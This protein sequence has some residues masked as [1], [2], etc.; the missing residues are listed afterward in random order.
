MAA[1]WCDDSATDRLWLIYS[2]SYLVRSGGVRWA[3]DPLTLA[4]RL[5]STEPVN[6]SDQQGLSFVLHT[7]SHTDHMGLHLI[8]LLCHLPIR[9]VVPPLVD[10]VTNR[11]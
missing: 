1:E 5:P 9:W 10:L 6:P 4:Y 2:A 11:A 7:H 8:R 3:F